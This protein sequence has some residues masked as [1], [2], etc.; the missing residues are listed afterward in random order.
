MKSKTILALAVVTALGSVAACNKTSTEAPGGKKLTIYKPADQSIKQGDTNKM[1]IRIDRDNF[2][3]KVDIAV[4]GLPIGVRVEGGPT[5]SIKA[6]DEKVQIIFI[7]DATATPV[8]D[9]LTTVTATT[10]GLSA[11]TEVFKLTVKAK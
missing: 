3:S 11:V 8:T 1:D 2:D 4:S 6:G 5:F 10:E 9:H 7:A